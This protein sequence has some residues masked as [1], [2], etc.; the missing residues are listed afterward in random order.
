MRADRHR[1][2]EIKDGMRQEISGILKENEG[3]IS[4]RVED[5][6]DTGVIKP[7]LQNNNFSHRAHQPEG[8]TCQR[9]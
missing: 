8:T 1:T 5:K 7:K 3:R 9:Q 6:A 2:P 4:R